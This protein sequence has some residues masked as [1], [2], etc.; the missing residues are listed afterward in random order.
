[1][2]SPRFRAAP[3][4]LSAIWV[5]V[6]RIFIVVIQQGFMVFRPVVPHVPV[7]C[8]YFCFGMV[9]LHSALFVPYFRYMFEHF[10]RLVRSD[11]KVDIVLV[12]RVL[13]FGVGLF[14]CF[15]SFLHCHAKE[16]GR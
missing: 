15:Q 6:P 3:P 12:L 13:H 14:Q 5:L 9:E 1:M 2:G 7:R 11:H 16:G 10:F 4:S 8:P